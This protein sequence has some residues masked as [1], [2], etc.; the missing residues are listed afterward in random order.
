MEHRSPPTTK[1][2]GDEPKKLHQVFFFMSDKS[3]KKLFRVHFF[4]FAKE[5]KEKNNL[6]LFS[7]DFASLKK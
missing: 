3:K 6:F 7:Y 1:N 4:D 2:G 5:K